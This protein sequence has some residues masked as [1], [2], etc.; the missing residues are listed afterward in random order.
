M[1]ALYRVSENEV[2]GLCSLAEEINVRGVMV[3]I[4]CACGES[5]EI[6]SR[7]FE[8]VY[9]IDPWVRVPELRFEAAFDAMKAKHP[10]VI[11][12][13]GLDTDFLD[14][15][16]VGCLD[17]VYIDAEHDYDSVK[18]QIMDWW[19]KLCRMGVLG[20]HDYTIKGVRQAV[21]EFFDEPDKVFEDSSWL[22]VLG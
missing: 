20:G 3:E 8:K 19:P 21:D 4:G 10:N 5:T 16:P 12:L 7:Y 11:K 22:V 17:F 18:K 2:S 1:C 13:K 9:A 6:F 14:K 15:F